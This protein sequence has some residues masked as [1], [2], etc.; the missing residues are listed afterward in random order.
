MSSKDF[1]RITIAKNIIIQYFYDNNLKS[2]CL[3]QSYILYKYIQSLNIQAKLK[4]GYIID[5]DNKIY[6]GHFWV[7]CAGK[8]YDIA[9]E[10][11]LKYQN[12]LFK[13]KRELSDNAPSSKE[14]ICIDSAGFEI[15]QKK[16]YIRCLDGEFI[17]DLKENTDNITYL[18]IK[19]I[20]DKILVRKI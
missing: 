18:K 2:S 7:E 12:N 3:S 20:Y 19:E 10:T 17:N 16:A 6:W 8:V 9:T 1:K 15:I 14:Y 5:N 13:S 11:F 4:K